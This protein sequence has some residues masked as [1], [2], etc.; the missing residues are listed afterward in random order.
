MIYDE[1]RSIISNVF[2]T[3]LSEEENKYFNEY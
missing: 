2:K 1:Y 3:G